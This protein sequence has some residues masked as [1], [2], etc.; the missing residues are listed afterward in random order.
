MCQTQ[1]LRT[2]AAVLILL[3]PAKIFSAVSDSTHNPAVDYVLSICNKVEE[4]NRLVGNLNPDSVSSLP[5]GIVKEIGIT[6]YIIAIDSAKFKPNGAYFNAYMALE[7]PGSDQKIAFEARNILFNPKGVAMGYNTRLVLVSETRIRIGPKLSLVLKPDGHNYV[8]WDCNGF[9]SVN[10]KG[11][12]EFSPGMIYPDS[13]STNEQT[14]KAQFEVNTTDIH[15]FITHI[16][17]TPFC[18]RGLNDVSFSVTDA[19]VDMSELQ[20]APDMVFPPSYFYSGDPQAWQGFFMKQFKIKLPPE[21][22]H[23]NTRT[24]LF[25]NNFLIDHSGVSGSFQASN[26]LSINDGSMSGWAFSVDQIGL[27]LVSNHVNG[28]NLSGRVRL[29]LCDSNAVAF[30]ASISQNTYTQQTDYSFTISP[31]S[32]ISAPVLSAKLD[33]YPTS[34]LTVQK[35]AGHFRPEAE[36]NGKISI[37]H[38]NVK[39]ADLAFQQVVLSTQSPYLKSGVFSLTSNSSGNHAG[40]FPITINDITVAISPTAP[41]IGL[42]VAFNFMSAQDQ[43]FAASTHVSVIAKIEQQQN[44]QHW[45]FDHVRVDDIALNVQTTAFHLHGNIKFK[46]NDP[47]YGKGFYGQLGISVG[48]ALPGEITA[49]SWFGTANNLKYWY[50]DAVVPAKIELGGTA[51]SLYRIMG[52]LYYHMHQQTPPGQLTQMLYSPAFSSGLTYIP[53]PNTAVGFKAGVTIGTSGD[54]KPFNGDAVFEVAFNS[55]MNGGGLNYVKLT[56]DVFSMTTIANRINRP[57]TQQKVYGNMVMNFDFNNH[58]FHSVINA[59]INLPQVSG[60]GQAV[61]HAEPGIWYVCIGK[62]SNRVHVTVGG[63]AG[64][65]AYFMSGTQLEPMPPPPSLVASLVS[66]SGLNNLRDQNKLV[67][68]KGL[69]FGAGFQSSASAS[70]GFDFFEVY[71]SYSMTVGFDMM[72]NDYGPNAHCSNSMD[73]IGINGWHASGQVYAALQGSVGVRGHIKFTPG[74][75]HGCILDTDFDI[76]ILSGTVA[77]LLYAQVPRPSYLAGSLA[78][79]YDILGKVQGNFDFNF[80]IGNQCTVVN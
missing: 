77:A 43:G 47:V 23:G 17:V 22:S 60:S 48:D 41:A 66:S 79:H 36:L 54:E 14:V 73:V 32:N 50:V 6:R 4:D 21:L 28:G 8:E 51:L 29:P 5:I 65:N 9:H 18:I 55:G 56:G 2:L 38:N 31:T 42:F 64:I 11:Y 19:I 24:E 3:L 74:C 71:G 57:P 68:A 12:F 40:N 20:N 39:A 46:E 44:T 59:V 34:R 70:F 16:S 80:A 49:S 35:T 13:T 1:Q 15:N 7:F 45:S 30:N 78:C 33:L 76:T 52:G 75:D 53:D 58:A 67:N 27:T 69:V 37:D 72:I 25:A 26:V 61:I 10:L 63:L 62:P